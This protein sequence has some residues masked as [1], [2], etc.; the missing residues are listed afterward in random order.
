M[1]SFDPISTFGELPAARATTTTR[2]GRY[3]GG[4]EDLRRAWMIGLHEATNR[5]ATR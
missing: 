2:D 4:D 1:Q 5:V 3:A